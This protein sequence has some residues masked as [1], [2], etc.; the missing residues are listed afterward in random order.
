MVFLAWNRHTSSHFFTF[1]M[2]LNI[3]IAQDSTFSKYNYTRDVISSDAD[4]VFDLGIDFF[5]SATS[6]RKSG[7]LYSAGIGVFTATLFLADKKFK[8]IASNNDV[9]FNDKLFKI[10]GL[11]N[12]T[13]GMYSSIGIYLTGYL[14]MEKNLRRIGLNGIETIILSQTITSALKYT[15]GRRR[16]FAG[17]SNMNFKL[18]RGSKEKYRSFPSGHTTGAFA[19]ASVMAMSLE[20][21]FWKTLWYGSAGLVALARIYHNVH[22]LSDTFFAAVMSY[23]IADYVVNFDN[24]KETNLSIQPNLRGISLSYHF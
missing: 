13:T 2:L 1:F 9:K 5:K 11:L 20:N 21:I 22:W 12:G 8:K 24:D 14:L 23:S 18:F 19:F 16:P 17:D 7:L 15:F 3:S 6:M 4:H 10:D